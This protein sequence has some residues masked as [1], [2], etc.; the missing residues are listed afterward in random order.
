[1]NEHEKCYQEI[2]VPPEMEFAIYPDGEDP[3]IYQ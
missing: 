2:Y 1:M 3:H